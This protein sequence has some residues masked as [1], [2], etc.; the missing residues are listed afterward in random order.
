[1][2]ISLFNSSVQL[3]AKKCTRSTEMLTKVVR[4]TFCT[5]RGDCMLRLLV[6]SGSSKEEHSVHVENHF[7][8]RCSQC[9]YSARTEGRLRR[10]VRDFHSTQSDDVSQTSAN[11]ASMK[12]SRQ[13]QQQH[14]RLIKCRQCPFST[15]VR[16]SDFISVQSSFKN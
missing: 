14:Q 5:N 11:T 6:L 15:R 7:E 3:H 12:F 1:M 9:S 8:H 2:C 10:H 13:H 4:V 16:V